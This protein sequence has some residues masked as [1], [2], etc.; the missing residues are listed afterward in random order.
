[1]SKLRRGPVPKA[2]DVTMKM[3]L[4]GWKRI[5]II[6]SVVWILVAYGVTFTHAQNEDIRWHVTLA[7][8]CEARHHGSDPE[9]DRILYTDNRLQEHETAAL[10]AFVPVPIAWG[11]VY[12]VLFLTQWV[13]RGFESKT[14]HDD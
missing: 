9:C 3:K 8:N 6:L 13:K 7:Q 1:M 14:S 4:N 12:V 10:V 5:G 11:F 2:N